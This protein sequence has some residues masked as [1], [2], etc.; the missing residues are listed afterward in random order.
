MFAPTWMRIINMCY[1]VFP[2]MVLNI[3]LSHNSFANQVYDDY[4]SYKGIEYEHI[5]YEYTKGKTTPM[6]V[7]TLINN[8]NVKENSLKNL[9]DKDPKTV[10][11][12]KRIEDDEYSSLQIPSVVVRFIKS[13]YPLKVRILPCETKSPQ[14]DISIGVA[15]KVSSSDYFELMG[16]KDIKHQHQYYDFQMLDITNNLFPA[17]RINIAFISNPKVEKICISE[18]E[19]V[20]NE[21]TSYKPLHSCSEVRSYINKN[22][23]YLDKKRAP[24]QK[25][26]FINENN[27]VIEDRNSQIFSDLMYYAL[28][29]NKEAQKI[30]FMGKPF[31]ETSHRHMLSDQEELNKLAMKEWLNKKIELR[32]LR[33]FSELNDYL[34]SKVVKQD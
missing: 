25:W 23:D 12:S 26:Q 30:F 24:T 5:D 8:L 1:R 10:W 17:N 3:I 20:L 15:K 14:P 11:Y 19:I 6:I 34:F 28:N 22:T 16:S 7:Y 33:L 9:F 32:W 4:I 31:P 29:D 18:I 27:E 21:S 13:V 2:I